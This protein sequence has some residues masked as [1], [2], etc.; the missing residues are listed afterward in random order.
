MRIRKIKK[1]IVLL[2]IMAML[3][4]QIVSLSNIAWA[5]NMEMTGET[6]VEEGLG[7]E[8]SGEV[9]TE[10]TVTEENPEETTEEVPEENPE[11]VPEEE[12]E[13]NPE[14]VPEEMPEENPEEVLEEEPE[15]NP[16]EVPEE[17][18]EEVP[19][20]VPEENPEVTE[21]TVV[22][23]KVELNIISENSSIYKGYLYAN[24]TSDLRYETNYNTIEEVKIEGSKNGISRLVVKEEEDKIKMIT[25]T[26]MALFNDIYY[27]KTRVSVD[28]FKN[29]LGE[30]GLINIFD[31][32]GDFVGYI[33]TNSP[34]VNGYYEYE[35]VYYTNSVTFELSSPIA[36]GTIKIIND[37]AIKE[38]SL[39]SRSQIA[40]FDAIN[41][42]ANAEM[43]V[44]D[45]VLTTSGE[46]NITLQETES[47][48]E[49]ELDKTELST[50]DIN[51]LTMTLTLKTD[52][53][54]YELFENPV[55]EVEMPSNINE[56]TI[57]GVNLLYKNGLSLKNWEV[58]ENDNGNKVLRVELEGAQSVYTPGIVQQGTTLVMY[59]KANVNKLTANT[60]ETMKL[61]Y[62]NQDSVRQAYVLE[63]KDAEETLITFVAKHGM[64]KGMVATN[65]VTSLAGNSYEDEVDRLEIKSNA[66]EQKVT[67]KG[68]VVN[69]F[70]KEVNDV[71]I[72]GRIPF[73]GNKNGNGEELLSDFDTVLSSE[74]MT[75]GNLTEIYYSE[76]G[77]A[78][79]DSDSWS[80][81]VTDMSKYKSY[82]IVVQEGTL[83]KGEKVEFTYDVMTPENLGYNLKSF[84]TYSVIYKLDNQELSGNCTIALVTEEKELEAEDMDKQEEVEKLKIG[85]QVTQGGRVLT[86]E[87]S[88]FERQMLKYTV[89]VT[90]TSKQT[91]TNVKLTGRAENANLYYM[92]V[93]ALDYNTAEN[94]MTFRYEEDVKGEKIFDEMLIE[95]LAPGESKTFS[96]QVVT[97]ELTTENQMVYGIVS[98][99]ADNLEEK[100]IETIKNQVKDGKLEM[101]IIW[102]ATESVEEKD[103]LTNEP[104]EFAVFMKNITD[105]KLENITL[106]VE[107]PKEVTFNIETDVY[108][109]TG[110]NRTYVE[111]AEGGLLTFDVSSLEAG[112]SKELYIPVRVKKLDYNI[113]N[114]KLSLRAYAQIGEERYYSNDYSKV[115]WQ[116]ET[117]VNYKWYSNN[118]V[119]TINHEEQ[120]VYTLELSN[121]GLVDASVVEILN[122]IPAG[123]VIE[124][125]TLVDDTGTEQTVESSN[126]IL[127]RTSIGAGK[128]I[129]LII[130]AKVDENA[131]LRDQESIDNKVTVSGVTFGEF[132]TDVISYK[133]NNKNVTIEIPENNEEK[134]DNSNNNNESNNDNENNNQDNNVSDDNNLGNNDDNNDD[135][136]ENTN[137]QNPEN[138]INPTPEKEEATKTYII[139]GKVWLDENKDG[140]NRNEPGMQSVVVMLYKTTDKGNITTMVQQKVTDSNGEYKFTSVEDGNYVVVF[141]YDTGLY[142]STK[143]HV[144]TASTNENSDAITKAISIGDS[145]DIY[146]ITDMITINGS[147]AIDVDLGLV[148]KNEFDLSLEKYIDSAVVTNA[149]GK[150][151]FKYEEE[152][153]VKLEIHSKYFKNS[154]IDITYKIRV[155]NSGEVN[156]Y[157]NKLV[158]YVPEDMKFDNNKNPEWYYGDDGN[159][160]Y[161]GLVG[162]EIKPGEV[163]EITLVLTKVLDEGEAVKIVNGAEI[164][165]STNSIGLTDMDSTP[166]NKQKTED[167]Y[168]EVSLMVTIST[169]STTRNLTIL[170]ITLLIIITIVYI[171]KFKTTKKVYR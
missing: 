58:V 45:I 116:S 135:N 134:D 64:L 139:S 1:I 20:E 157:V 60:S 124:N 84:A 67:L 51:E 94:S 109:S 56:L 57:E 123:L 41:V 6:G 39:Y 103:A 25:E 95:S 106:N 73:V 85:T 141:S 72:L 31:A 97:K 24:A 158:D 32:S 143:Y 78:T 30:N 34:E 108:G 90:N 160:Y 42:M 107:L 59:L 145:K 96:Y 9:S 159:L 29:I 151:T 91:L 33:D 5:I 140:V 110:L 149:N 43:T 16:E 165:E 61:R 46:G 102:G 37:K 69:N 130:T 161:K 92:I 153:N 17:M 14:E 121:D 79:V 48:I 53:E 50:E 89:V 88:V 146:G 162:K 150:Q 2:I 137:L 131:F 100:T 168:G 163:R 114:I 125:V 147:G 40:T 104:L 63:G 13:E 82:K 136:Q 27:K 8:A 127:V 7:T 113:E 119:E 54:R 156:G 93:E 83:K 169:G 111:N 77:E 21:E 22:E 38:D 19:E 87:D 138:Q 74:I 55:M 101:K 36:D 112:E 23:P 68:T 154:Q 164:A 81:D 80:Q 70:E 26:K 115:V 35:F 28:E 118:K 155:K 49:M 105:T 86:E 99:S 75:T 133:I 148:S 71:V 166:G 66:V 152:K 120:V 11:E 3:Q 44:G 65:N 52:A 122:R 47:K 18:P 128:D 10:A 167:D 132:E 4:T 142:N 170:I 126:I 76:D 12:P 171:A 15:E 129:K 117:K 62:T 98:V 144:S